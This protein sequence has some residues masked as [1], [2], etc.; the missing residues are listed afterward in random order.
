MKRTLITLLF[1]MFSLMTFAQKTA[2][3]TISADVTPNDG[4]TITSVTFSKISGPIGDV[5]VT[6]KPAAAPTV[7]TVVNSMNVGVYVYQLSVTD[8]HGLT[9]SAT[10]KVTVLASYAPPT[11]SAGPDQIIRIPN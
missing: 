6:P 3:T 7:S 10:L 9:A 11:I 2:S 4:S 1:A 8:S 5:I